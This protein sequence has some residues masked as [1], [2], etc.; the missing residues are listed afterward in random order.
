MRNS[1]K[2]SSLVLVLLICFGGMS[3]CFSQTEQLYRKPGTVIHQADSPVSAAGIDITG[4]RLEQVKLEKPWGSAT[5]PLDRVFRI[6]IVAKDSFLKMV[7]FSIWVADNQLQSARIRPNE[8]ATL[9]F[10]RTLPTNTLQLA[11]SKSSER[12]LTSR[13]ILPEMLHVPSEYATPLSEIEAARPVV[14][15]RKNQLPNRP[16]TYELTVEFSGVGCSMESM[17]NIEIDGRDF[18]T[19][20]T[21]HALVAMFISAND[22]ALM[23][24]GS[25]IAIKRRVD[26]EV[27]RY[28]VGLLNKRLVIDPLK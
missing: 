15:M 24:D 26:R 11:I 9:L 28:V 5:P 19:H 13:I 17:E 14:K 18:G 23:K 16:P 4:Y 12:T 20:C 22:F 7:D 10:S 21:G 25:E 6:V 3:I 8:F 27:R 2:R 1:I